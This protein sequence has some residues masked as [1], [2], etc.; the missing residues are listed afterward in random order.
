M[1]QAP[2]SYQN[3]LYDS[4]DSARPPD[5]SCLHQEPGLTDL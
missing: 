5:M 3:L 4:S 1:T 2:L